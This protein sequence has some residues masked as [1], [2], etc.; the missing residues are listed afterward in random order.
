MSERWDFCKLAI[1][2]K[3]GFSFDCLESVQTNKVNLAFE[4]VVR[5]EEELRHISSLV[6]THLSSIPRP[7]RHRIKRQMRQLKP[8]SS[9]CLPFTKVW[10]VVAEQRQQALQEFERIFE[11][12][13]QLARLK[14]LN[15]IKREKYREAVM[16]CSRDAIDGL[17]RLLTREHVELS[18]SCDQRYLLSTALR[19]LQRFCTKNEIISFFGPTSLAYLEPEMNRNIEIG[20]DVGTITKRRVYFAWWA[21]ELLRQ[22][23]LGLDNECRMAYARDGRVLMKDHCCLFDNYGIVHCYELSPREADLLANGAHNIGDR[24]NQPTKEL[25]RLLDLGL[26][27]P[28][29]GIPVRVMRPLAYLIER[30]Y[31]ILPKESIQLSH[32]EQLCELMNVLESSGYAD[33]RRILR[34]IDR[35]FERLT[36]RTAYR[37]ASSVF[38]DRRVLHEDCECGGRILLGG[39]LVETIQ[40]DIGRTLELFYLFEHTKQNIRRLAHY[41]W[42]TRKFGLNKAVSLMEAEDALRKD[43]IQTE[44]WQDH[45]TN[46]AVQRYANLR[47]KFLSLLGPAIKA[48]NTGTECVRLPETTIDA[49]LSQE[50]TDTDLGAYT[51]VDIQIS[52]KSEDNINEGDFL[53][54]FGE[55]HGTLGLRMCFSDLYDESNKIQKLLANNLESVAPGFDLAE[56]LIAGGTGA[57]KL[58]RLLPLRFQE[59]EYDS[60]SLRHGEHV[61]RYADLMIIA[62]D[63]ALR[64]FDKAT[65]RNILIYDSY[66]F[67]GDFHLIRS[68]GSIFSLNEQ[69]SFSDIRAP[70]ADRITRYPRIVIGRT[71]VYR[72]EW[73]I[74]V[75]DYPH[76][77]KP[78]TAKV[79][80]DLKKMCIEWNVPRHFM[81]RVEGWRKPLYVDTENILTLEML[82]Q[83]LGKDPL[84]LRVTEMLPSPDELWLRDEDGRYCC[85][86]SCTAFRIPSQNLTFKGIPKWERECFSNS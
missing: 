82:H 76:R 13:L 66:L 51:T 49:F 75:T 39:K 83:V 72:R 81:L 34:E 40:K 17:E 7:E 38:G 64:M 36:G 47:A 84:Q 37:K 58:S 46:Q 10:N 60:S 48:I 30:V 65:R 45:S 55:T 23:T 68:W 19:Y 56:I 79:F 24:Q 8:I 6:K 70:S 35:T 31:E 28:I 15:V 20:G 67:K 63:K 73:I 78:F 4:L 43:D 27:R 1:L 85:E 69:P 18:F 21:A 77:R 57:N 33:R 5:I 59:V 53:L 26:I 80:F 41:A 86:F 12:D 50:R 22:S 52:A 25:R 11:R 62:K 2:K 14:L 71:V 44:I 74:P 61:I 42:F 29:H 32:L 3:T 9:I 16:L 54:I